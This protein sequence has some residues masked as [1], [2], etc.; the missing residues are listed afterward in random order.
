MTVI[1]FFNNF[2][3]KKL[4]FLNFVKVKKLGIQNLNP[5]IL[6]SFITILL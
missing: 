2:N 4:D 1:R 5:I 6:L 3:K